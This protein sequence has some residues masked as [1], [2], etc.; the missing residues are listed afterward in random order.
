MIELFELTK[1]IAITLVTLGVLVS[2]HEFGHFWVARRCGVKVLCFSIGFGPKLF[3]RKDKDGTEYAVSLIPLGGYVKMLGEQD[4]DYNES[5]AD[6][7]F[8]RKSVYKRMAIVAAGPIANFLLA[9]A[10][11]W[12]VYLL[13]VTKVAP[14]VGEVVEQSPAQKA[15]ITAQQEILAVDGELTPSWRDVTMALLNRVGETGEIELT[16]KYPDS[17]ISYGYQLPIQD[18]HGGGNTEPDLLGSLG[19]KPFYPK[20][21]PVIEQVLPNS[22]AEKAGLQKDDK[23]IAADGLAMADWES[24]VKY[25]KARPGQVISLKVERNGGYITTSITP[26]TLETK[27]GERYGQAGVS[28]QMEPWPDSMIRK[29]E[30]NVFTAIGPAIQETWELSVFTLESVKKM[31]VGL[32]SPKNLSGPIT[33]AKVASSSADYGLQSYLGFLALLSI[34]LG[35]LNLLPIPVLDGGHLLFYVIEW[36]KG[37]PVSERVQGVA[38]QLGMSLVLCIMVFAIYNDFSRL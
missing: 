4:D 10:V 24:W 9:I 20:V 17:D 33:I 38:L 14:I 36:I 37:S 25:I 13:G 15:G 3:T 34:S 22:A 35:V 26:N 30:Y 23:L 2:F 11:F 32:I 27:T 8:N 12:V 21:L 7:A 6:L 16:A 5:E 1:T 28:P 19:L 18:W 29:L 31:I